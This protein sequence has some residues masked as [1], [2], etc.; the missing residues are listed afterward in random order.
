MAGQIL[1]PLPQ[2]YQL[3]EYT[4]DRKI[5]GGGFG[6]VYLARDQ[7]GQAVAI[8]EYSPDGVVTRV[9]D[10]TV[11]PVSEEKS[12]SFHHGMKYFFE[13]G[14]VLAQI[15]HPN[16]VRVVNFFRANDT[17]YMVMQYE[18]GKTLQQAIR[19]LGDTPMREGALRRIF[20]QLLNGLREVHTCK[21]LHLDIKPSN[22]Y[23]RK[24]GSPV[25]L[26]FGA[27]RQASSQGG[28]L[29]AQMYTPGYAAPEQFNQH[30]RLGPWTDIYGVGA[31]IYTCLAKTTPPPADARNKDDTFLDATAAFAD[32]YSPQLLSL[33]D[34]MLRLSYMQRPQSVFM[35]QKRLLE[36]ITPPV[37]RKAE[38]QT[39]LARIFD[40]LNQ[41]L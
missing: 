8:K 7:D 38:K 3:A 20:V 5:G 26:D 6:M 17:V 41:P 24:D 1:E 25:L 4:I 13:E 30:D 18:E 29:T 36:P 19:D 23:I 27:A 32:Q 35:V 31:S 2:G 9:E 22:I 39:M 28:Q 40:R 34:S 10:G 14:R 33:V 16:V 12:K 37:P 21:L 11:Q 15:R